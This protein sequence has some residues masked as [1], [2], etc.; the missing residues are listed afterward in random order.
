MSQARLDIIVVYA[1]LNIPLY[2]PIVKENLIMKKRKKKRSM[3]LVC[4][5]LF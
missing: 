3:K 1:I 5:T 2:Y 4:E